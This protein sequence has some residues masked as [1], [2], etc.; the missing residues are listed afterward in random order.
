MNKQPELREEVR[1]WEAPCVVEVGHV[2]DVVTRR[3]SARPK[4]LQWEEDDD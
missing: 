2:C 4:P 3:F 1:Q